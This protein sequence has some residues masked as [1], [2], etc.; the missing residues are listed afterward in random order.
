MAPLYALKGSKEFKWTAECNEAFVRVKELLISSNDLVHYSS[1]NPVG[2]AV[3]A[4][5]LG[6]V[7]SHT[8][9]HVLRG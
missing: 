6:A 9:T 8:D 3:D 4:Y 1:N 7:I 5:G 2:L